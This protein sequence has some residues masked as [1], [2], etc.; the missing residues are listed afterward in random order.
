MQIGDTM[1]KN[2]QLFQYFHSSNSVSRSYGIDRQLPSFGLEVLM[3]LIKAFRDEI[4]VPEGVN[5][6]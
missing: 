2:V 1:Y 5:P 3:T 4:N 6:K